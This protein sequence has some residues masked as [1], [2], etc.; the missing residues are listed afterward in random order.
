MKDEAGVEL[1]RCHCEDGHWYAECCDGSGGCSCGG[2]AMDMGICN[3]CGGSGWR[4]PDADLT[5]NAK[6]IRSCFLGS[7]PRTGYW[8]GK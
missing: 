2:R 6:T 4:R 8:A 3:V 7:G 1:V 5:A